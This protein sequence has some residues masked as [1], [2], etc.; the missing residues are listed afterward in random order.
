MRSLRSE[1]RNQKKKK[2][3]LGDFAYKA[4]ILKIFGSRHPADCF[5]GQKT[6]KIWVGESENSNITAFENFRILSRERQ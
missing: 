1:P 5:S 3:I 4:V 6:I 2:K